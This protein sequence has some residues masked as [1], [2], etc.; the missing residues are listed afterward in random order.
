MVGDAKVHICSGCNEIIAPYDPEAYQ[1]GTFYYH[2]K[3]HEDMHASRDW[4]DFL[5]AEGKHSRRM[6]RELAVQP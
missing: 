4:N 6:V 3:A 2:S 1:E 5:K